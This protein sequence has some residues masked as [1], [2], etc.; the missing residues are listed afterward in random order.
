MVEAGDFGQELPPGAREDGG[1]GWVTTM[2]VNTVCL[3]A[4][5]P[6]ARAGSAGAGG[7]DRYGR[8]PRGAPK[9]VDKE[10][11]KSGRRWMITPRAGL[12][13][14]QPGPQPA[15]EHPFRLDYGVR[16]RWKSM[17]SGVGLR[18]RRRYSPGPRGR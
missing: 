18:E 2:M 15:C 12:S 17:G 1:P 5:S 7:R 6:G 8:R 10:Q 11:G 9:A 3:S 13:L 14:L 4:P 16:D